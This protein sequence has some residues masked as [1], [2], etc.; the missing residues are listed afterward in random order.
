MSY[1][2][3]CCAAGCKSV[4]LGRRHDVIALDINKKRIRSAIKN[5]KLFGVLGKIR[6]ICG[7][8]LNSSLLSSLGKFSAIFI[9]ADWRENLHDPIKKQNLDP[10]KT[11]PRTDKLFT[12]LRKVFPNSALVFKV[13]PFVRVKDM[14]HLGPCKIEEFYINGKFLCYYVY[15]S[16]RIKSNS[17][18]KVFKQDCR[19][20]I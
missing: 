17:Y 16:S 19:S 5:S 1:L 14:R 2:E 7:S 4:I 15:Y 6:F 3:L 13:S 11:T 8:V 12:L 18:K 20:I 9:D 10:I